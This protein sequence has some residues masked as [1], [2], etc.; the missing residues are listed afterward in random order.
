MRKKIKSIPL[1]N[2]AETFGAGIAIG[3]ASIRDSRTFEDAEQSHRDDYHLFF[4]QEKG[5]TPVEVDFQKHEIKPSCVIYIH[6]N[7][8]HR[9]GPFENVTLSFLAINN[10]NLNPEFLKV[11]EDITPAKPLLLN[12]ETFLIV[13]EAVSLCISIAERKQEKLYHSLLKESCNTL[14]ALIASQYL[15]QAKPGDPYS[16]PEIISKAF[17]S[18]LERDFTTVKKPKE[19]AQILNISTPYLNDCV[20]NSTGHSVSY[21]IQQHL[22]LEA[23]RLLYHSDKSVKEIASELGYDDYTYFSRLFT[24]LTGMTALTFRNKTRD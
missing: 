7:Q 23:K 8:V 13:S 24:K 19:Y 21:H 3:K 12:K 15:E 18:I 14:V 20:K 2:M 16:R 1:N 11:L 9:I 5:I 6:P 4:L 10:E 22:I 17:R